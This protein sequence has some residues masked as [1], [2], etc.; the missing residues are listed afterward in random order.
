MSGHWNRSVRRSGG[1]RHVKIIV[2]PSATP[3]PFLT[4]Q[5]FENRHN[6]C[7][8]KCSFTG[9]KCECKCHAL[10]MEGK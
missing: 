3:K 10:E 2:S 8:G 4:I 9:L 7:H 1:D 5:C 6:D